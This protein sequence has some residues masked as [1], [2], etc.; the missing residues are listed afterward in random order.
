MASY[1]NFEEQ[2]FDNETLRVVTDKIEELVS[3]KGGAIMYLWSLARA[4]DAYNTCAASTLESGPYVKNRA[5]NTS[6]KYADMLTD[7]RLIK[8][9]RNGRY[10]VNPY[11]F[12]KNIQHLEMLKNKW[13]NM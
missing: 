12:F 5:Y 10:M 4:M 11:Y 6:K 2:I 9:T 1:L 8:K 3:L 13:D 7:H